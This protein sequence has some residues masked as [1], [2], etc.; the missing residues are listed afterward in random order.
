MNVREL[1]SH[2][3]VNER[4]LRY[5]LRALEG[6]VTGVEVDGVRVYAPEDCDL[7]AR[8]CALFGEGH[9]SSEVRRRL[10]GHEPVNPASTLVRQQ[11]GNGLATIAI[12]KMGDDLA[13]IRTALEAIADALTK[14]KDESLSSRPS[15]TQEVTT[16]TRTGKPNKR[17]IS[18]VVRFIRQ[19]ELPKGWELKGGKGKGWKLRKRKRK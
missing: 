4:T 6:L 1:A 16:R 5:R 9:S 17:T 12:T 18:N 10:Q 11:D 3:A 15:A 8:A 7:V 13:A 14:P 2:L 19:H